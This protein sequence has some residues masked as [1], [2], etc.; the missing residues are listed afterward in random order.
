M[1]ELSLFLV[2]VCLF[3]GT[4]ADA[5]EKV[6]SADDLVR[7]FEKATLGTLKQDIEL[8]NDLD[9]S[10]YHL[11]L[12]TSDGTCISYSGVFEG[13]NH[14]IRNLKMN[15][16][17]SEGYNHAGLFCNLKDATI[18]NLIIDSSCSFTGNWSGGLSVTATGSLNSINVTNKAT[19]K[20]KEQ[21]GGFIAR[22]SDNNK[23]NLSI[24]NCT[25]DAEI[26]GEDRVG[27][28]VGY[29][30][31]STLTKITNCSNYGTIIGGFDV[32]GF[33][34]FGFS[35]AKEVINVDHCKNSGTVTARNGAAGG[36]IGTIS[37]FTKTDVTNCFSNGTINT[38]C[39]NCAIGGLIGHVK[40]EP[41]YSSN[42]KESILKLI[43]NT[44]D[45]QWNSVKTS[46]VGGVIG[47]INGTLNLRVEINHTNTSGFLKVIKQ[48]AELPSVH[49]GGFIGFA[50]NNSALTI[51]ISNSNNNCSITTT[52]VQK[53]GGFIEIMKE[54]EKVELHNVSNEGK[55][56]SDEGGTA[57]FI[58]DIH[59]NTNIKIA[60][61][62][63]SNSGIVHGKENSSGFIGRVSEN[64]HM[65]LNFS[66]CKNKN[67]TIFNDDDD[68]I[69][70]INYIG[71][72]VGHI[73]ENYETNI[74]ITHCENMKTVSATGRFVG[75]FVGSFYENKVT[76]LIII[77]SKNMGMAQ[78]QG[79][80][81]NDNVGG[82]VGYADNSTLTIITYCSNNGTING[83]YDVGGFIGFGF[84][85]MDEQIVIDH[86]NNSGTVT[87]KTGAAGGIIGTISSFS[88]THV[89]NC[90][91]NGTINT[92]C[93]N[94]AIGGLIGRVQNEP[95]YYSNN[96]ESTL[97]LIG[98]TCEIHW[99]CTNKSVV[100]GVIGKINGTLNLK[101]EIDKTYTN[102]L[103]TVERSETKISIVGVGGFIGFV[104]NNSDLTIEISNSNN[105]CSITT[106]NVTKVG[107]FIGSV[108]NNKNIINGP[109]IIFTNCKNH[110]QIK[111]T[112]G[113]NV[114]GFIGFIFNILRVEAKDCENKGDILINNTGENIAVGGFIGFFTDDANVVIDPKI[115]LTGT[116]NSGSV[117]V[118]GNPSTA[119]VGGLIGAIHEIDGS[120]NHTSIQIIKCSN[121]GPSIDVRAQNDVQIG[122]LIGNMTKNGYFNV[123]IKDCSNQAT[124]SALSP[125]I[126]CI[127]GG[128][129]GW[130]SRNGRS[131]L[132]FTG[133]KN[134]GML[135]ASGSHN[136][137]G[138]FV[139]SVSRNRLMNITLENDK[140][141]GSVTVEEE[142]D[143]TNI[144]GIVGGVEENPSM[145]MMFNFVRNK[146]TMSTCKQCGGNN[147]GLVGRL[148]LV[149]DGT[150]FTFSILNSANDGSIT[151]DG[152]MSLSCGLVCVSSESF[153]DDRRIVEVNNSINRGFIHGNTSYG[154]A[155]KVT[156]ASNVVS[157]GDVSGK[158][159]SNPFFE[160]DKKNKVNDCYVLNTSC[161]NI[162]GECTNFSSESG[163]YIT[164]GGEEVHV[165]LNE[166]AMNERYGKVWNECLFI[167]DGV[168]ITLTQLNDKPFVL[169]KGTI[170]SAFMKFSI[171]TKHFGNLKH[172][173]NKERCH[174]ATTDDEINST[175]KFNER[176]TVSLCHKVTFQHGYIDHV[177]VEDNTLLNVTA[178]PEPLNTNWGK[179]S[180]K[181]GSDDFKDKKVTSD[182]K[183]TVN[184]FCHQLDHSACKHFNTTC[185]DFGSCR[186]KSVAYF[187]IFTIAFEVCGFLGA[188]IYVVVTFNSPNETQSSKKKD[189]KI[190]RIPVTVPDP[191]QYPDDEESIG[192]LEPR[193]KK[194]K[195]VF[196]VSPNE[197]DQLGSGRFGTVFKVKDDEGNQQTYAVKVIP[198]INHFEASAVKKEMEQLDTQFVLEVLGR[199]YYDK[200][201]QFVA[202]VFGCEYFN[203]HVAI[204]ME[205]FSLGSLRRMLPN[206][207]PPNARVPMLLDIAKAMKHLHSLGKVHYHLKPENVLV[208]SVDPRVHPMCKFVS[209]F[210][211]I[212]KGKYG[213]MHHH[214]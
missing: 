156:S 119:T 137:V 142:N 29:A 95:N 191:Q 170:V 185:M 75:G 79:G 5:V 53:G 167:T 180:L 64:S 130:V 115:E 49:T 71:G 108:L 74:N 32:G 99:E 2:F 157:I 52:N 171:I 181:N 39:Q 151:N 125:Q 154:I 14:S 192:L 55:V 210:S 97:K 22:V 59:N 72:F 94:C 198:V 159:S 140:N 172:L 27:G 165:K 73:L 16:T 85:R 7:L 193:Y 21:A 40:N 175:V 69:N 160:C 182:V 195:R 118:E 57:G 12:G 124:I 54:G 93:Q 15:N 133:C 37:S 143:D 43:N 18:K 164:A 36:I 33:I 141:F 184:A 204:T 51:E 150:K 139:G 17:N 211:N 213:V 28:F 82:F 138:G 135:S 186:K 78:A 10:Q 168:T 106:T 201:V 127:V 70:G 42:S 86:C 161:S 132:T 214:E 41:N 113:S 1:R 148:D 90:F 162:T 87:A 188:L 205:Y 44:C 76:K 19:V 102:G 62:G 146:G 194:K 112:N 202:E 208:C 89:T 109:N 129:I 84:N 20:G 122:G 149:N 77:G 81:K 47:K 144:G 9:F 103:I 187:I 56:S 65:T 104:V 183:L 96:H 117:A 61:I 24:L 173:V 34:G 8:E 13:N 30:D 107:G 166:R 11:P 98:N 6:S 152:E 67:K 123:E 80:E 145:E 116:N 197:Q 111:S 50:E 120:L 58:S 68:I 126:T 206:K 134:K 66:Y 91:S 26:S 3:F 163:H 92:E 48:I 136:D 60:L 63:C 153:L 23:T 114:G 121:N 110:Q 31:N 4:V 178:V 199:K 196:F 179:Y 177:F 45:L 88:E 131:N 212:I 83:G 176:M 200:H 105:N 38:E 207:L 100:G 147:G 169:V 155:S 190:D 101:V 203:K 189:V 25:N 128:L 158:K 46:V 209:F 35:R 174:D